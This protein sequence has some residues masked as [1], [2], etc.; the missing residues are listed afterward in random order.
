MHR[1]TVTV[2]EDLNYTGGKLVEKLVNKGLSKQKAEE[3]VEHIH[4]WITAHLNPALKNLCRTFY[5]KLGI[6]SPLPT[7]EYSISRNDYIINFG[8]WTGRY[9]LQYEDLELEIVVKPKIEIAAF[10]AMINETFKLVEMIGIP[11]LD[12]LL[13]HSIGKGLNRYVIHTSHLLNILTDLALTEGLPPTTVKTL[14]ITPYCNTSLIHPNLTIKLQQQGKPLIACYKL[15]IEKPRLL[16]LLVTKFHLLLYQ[17]LKEIYSKLQ[18]AG[19]SSPVYSLLLSSIQALI[20][21]HT[22]TLS[23]EPFNELITAA[24]HATEETTQIQKLKT[25]AGHN[26]WLKRII[27]LYL[28]YITH[29]PPIVEIQKNIEKQLPLQPLPTSKLYELWILYLLIENTKPEKPAI[30][31]ADNGYQINLQKI[32]VYYNTS[33]KQ[34]SKI[35]SK[36]AKPPRP[37]YIIHHKGK[38][39]ALDAKY[40]EKPDTADIQRL[41]SYIIDITDPQDTKEIKGFIINLKT[42]TTL[43]R[44]D[45]KP[46][47]KIYITTANPEKPKQ[48]RQNIN[49]IIKTITS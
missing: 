41:I 12:V 43:Q 21:K 42:Q 7:S 4:Q 25:T 5:R 15:S 48:T 45:I 2:R 32:Q 40:K 31:P 8:Q 11:A 1:I 14:T 37:D 34:L 28:T 3:L 36:I 24:C 30:N 33:K 39:T 16:L 35:I 10:Q 44:T 38:N 46:P 26:Q 23:R 6:E 29:R 18:T 22:Y 9:K 20:Y 19:T 49:N 27:D 13:T 47:I 17:D